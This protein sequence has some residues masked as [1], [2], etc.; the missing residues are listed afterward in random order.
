MTGVGSCP[1]RVRTSPWYGHEC[2]DMNMKP[3][4]T[5]RDGEEGPDGGAGALLGTGTPV[6]VACCVRPT[7][8]EALQSMKPLSPTNTCPL[9]PCSVLDSGPRKRAMM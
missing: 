9:R 8:L 6:T 2:K 1:G 7:M 4:N 3:M 5:R